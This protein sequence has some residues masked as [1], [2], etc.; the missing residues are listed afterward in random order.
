MEQT[1]IENITQLR[2][3]I[4]RMKSVAKQQEEVVSKNFLKVQ[5]DLKPE[6]I[7]KNAFSRMTGLDSKGNGVLQDILKFGLS[8]FLQRFAIRAENK[9]EEKIFDLL[10]S[11]AER[12][13]HL[14]KKK[15]KKTED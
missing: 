3:E 5:N 12:F 10:A 6:N 1:K 15:N 4:A 2:A 9:V 13:K 8:L 11:A 14:F 7:L